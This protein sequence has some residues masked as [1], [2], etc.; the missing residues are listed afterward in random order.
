MVPAQPFRMCQILFFRHKKTPFQ[1]G[2]EPEQLRLLEKV[3]FLGITVLCSTRLAGGFLFRSL[4]LPQL[5]EGLNRKG[6][7][8]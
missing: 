2:R 5:P 1:C 3:F 4:P 7:Y 8:E 6:S